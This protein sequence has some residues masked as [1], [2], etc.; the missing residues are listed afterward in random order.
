MAGKF[1]V[2]Y[3]KK[4]EEFLEFINS[5]IFAANSSYKKS[6][7]YI[8]FGNN[9]LKRFTNFNLVFSNQAKNTKRNFLKIDE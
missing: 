4:P 1:A 6:W 5:E 9:S 7:E 3:R 8:A 2:R